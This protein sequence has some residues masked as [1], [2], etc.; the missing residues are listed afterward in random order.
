MSKLHDPSDRMLITNR[1]GRQYWIWKDDKLYEQRLG[2]ENGPYQARNLVMNRKCKPDAR[3]IIDVGVN[4]GMN[5][6][7]YATW[8]KNVKGFEP[9]KSSM[10]LARLNIDIA[11]QAKLKG[12]YWHNKTRT[13]LHQPDVP[14]GWFKFPDKTFASLD[15]VGNIELFDY[16]LGKE[17]KTITMEEKPNECSR[18]DALLMEGKET[19]NPTQTAEMRTLDSFGFEDVDI[20]KIDVEGSELFVIEGAVETIKKYQPIVQVELRDTHCKRFGYTP[21][22][23]INL[24]MSLGDYVMTDFNGTDLGTSYIKVKGVMDRFFIPRS[25]HATLDIKKKVHPGMLKNSDEALKHIGMKNKEQFD[26]LFDPIKA[27]S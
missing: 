2:R 26:E 4:I 11:K 27:N 8:A 16:A 6:I 21:D 14:D 10:E 13:H 24:M 9:M 23:I 18:G 15:L 1:I 20:I 5:S 19:K 22:D 12:K 17:N 7:E 25:I 3:T